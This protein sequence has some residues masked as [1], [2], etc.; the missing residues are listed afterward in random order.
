M[1]IAVVTIIASGAANSAGNEVT[2]KYDAVK[3]KY[4]IARYQWYD[5]YANGV[6]VKAPEAGKMIDQ[7]KD[8]MD[9]KRKPGG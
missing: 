9:K 3:N 4:D 5:T 6:M 1:Y 8:L 7:A 2:A